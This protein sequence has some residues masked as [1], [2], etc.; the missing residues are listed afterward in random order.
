MTCA[1][2]VAQRSGAAA[3]KLTF[4]LQREDYTIACDYLL[5]S[6]FVA[7]TPAR[8][9]RLWMWAQ[10]GRRRF[11][12]S[13]VPIGSG[14]RTT[15]RLK[16]NGSMVLF[17]SLSRDVCAGACART[18]KGEVQNHRTIELNPKTVICQSFGSSGSVLQRFYARTGINN[19]V[20]ITSLPSLWSSASIRALTE[21]RRRES[22][23]AGRARPGQAGAAVASIVGA[24]AD[25]AISMAYAGPMGRVGMAVLERS[26]FFVRY[27][28]VGDMVRKPAGLAGAVALGASASPVGT[29]GVVP[30]GEGGTPPSA[31]RSHSLTCA[32]P[33]FRISAPIPFRRIDR[34]DRDSR[35]NCDGQ[36]GSGDC[37]LFLVAMGRRGSAGQ[38]ERREWVGV[39]GVVLGWGRSRLPAT[40]WG[41]AASVN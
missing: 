8:L 40:L 38:I 9:N 14:G 2:S 4:A 3:P 25:R 7:R 35:L 28:C 23:G 19:G 30:I 36:M 33:I 18:Y 27:Q 16:S 5:N 22:F 39:Q 37:R 24:G 10:A 11:A 1:A 20:D 21:G 13:M 41:G 29:G 6:F 17:Y 12:G 32:Q 26:A 15:K 34:T 31:A